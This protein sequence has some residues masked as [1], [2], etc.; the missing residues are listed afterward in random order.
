MIPRLANTKLVN[1]SEIT[2]INF[3]SLHA[4]STP[5]FLDQSLFYQVQ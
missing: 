4:V 3:D 2:R 5:S 1:I